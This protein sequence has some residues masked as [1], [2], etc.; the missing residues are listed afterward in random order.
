M[1]VCATEGSRIMITNSFPANNIG[2]GGGA[3]GARTRTK[4]LGLYVEEEV[5]SAPLPRE[6][7]K[8]NF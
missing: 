3:L 5:V 2:V 4:I 1:H 8:S 6:N 7:E